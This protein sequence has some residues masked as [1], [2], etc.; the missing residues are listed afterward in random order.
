MKREKDKNKKEENNIATIGFDGVM[1]IVGD[2][3]N[4]TS[5]DIDWIVDSGASFHVSCYLE[6]FSSYIA[7]ELGSVR[8][9]DYKVCKIAGM[10]DV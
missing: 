10:G 8:V 2:R 3:G 4:L 6:S 1:V 9:G 5:Q 7:G